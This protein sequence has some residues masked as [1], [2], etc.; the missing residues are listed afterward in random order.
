MD[1]LPVHTTRE[2]RK[3]G[4]LP[5]YWSAFLPQQPRHIETVFCPGVG[6]NPFAAPSDDPFERTSDEL[7]AKFWCYAQE[8]N[9][10]EP[11]YDFLSDD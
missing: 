7:T 2:R 5:D 9:F 1:K 11:E 8:G 4:K 10:F 3:S 6:F